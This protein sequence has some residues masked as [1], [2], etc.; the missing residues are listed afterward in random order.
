MIA[1][2]PGMPAGRRRHGGLTVAGIARLAGVS[3]PTVSRVI[4]G[5]SGVALSTR[6]RVESVIREHGYRRAAN[7]GPLAILQLVF[8]PLGSLWGVEI[9]PRGEPGAPRPE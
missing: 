6:Q 4:N 1:A 2:G 9:I 7:R 3:A 5:Q 8:H